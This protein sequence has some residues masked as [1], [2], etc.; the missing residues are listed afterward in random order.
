MCFNDDFYNF[1]I[2]IGC[3]TVFLLRDYF[4]VQVRCYSLLRKLLSGAKL[5]F[6]EFFDIINYMLEFVVEKM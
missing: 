5:F 3:D 1:A 6:S 4:C 2:S